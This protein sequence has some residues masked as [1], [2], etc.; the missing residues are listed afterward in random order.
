MELK[1]LFEVFVIGD[2]KK[3]ACIFLHFN[4]LFKAPFFIYVY[5]KKSTELRVSKHKRNHVSSFLM[6]GCC[7]LH[8]YLVPQSKKN[9]CILN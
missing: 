5:K 8:F 4:E 2:K 6:K 9:S 1:G 7:L 3:A